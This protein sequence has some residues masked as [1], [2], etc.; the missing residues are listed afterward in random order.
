MSISRR[1][2]V[3]ALIFLAALIVTLPLAGCG[4]NEP[5]T[6]GDQTPGGGTSQGGGASP[7]GG[8]A[9]P[10]SGAGKAWAYGQLQPGQHVK[11]TMRGELGGAVQTGWFSWDV[12]DAG[13]GRLKI[14]Y[15][16]HFAD[17]DY[18]DAA[19]VS[20]ETPLADFRVTP[21]P[22]YMVTLLGPFWGD[23]LADCPWTVGS[24]WS[25]EASIGLLGTREF[26]L[27]V[28][29]TAN[30][31][32][33]DGFTGTWTRKS[34]GTVITTSW[35]VNPDLPVVLYARVADSPPGVYEYTLIEATGF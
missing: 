12:T 4:K 9:E 22:I 11:Y 29:G 30:Y 20:A 28:T 26:V 34:S 17:M 6:S 13:G 25:T 21:L 27:E 1:D 31:A 35:C 19:T 2:R 10:G 8:S 14:A 3:A 33:I 16:G 18:S 32:D 23:I 24:K 5:A 7:G 15:V